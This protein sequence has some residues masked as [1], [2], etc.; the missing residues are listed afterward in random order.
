MGKNNPLENLPCQVNMIIKE[1]LIHHSERRIMKKNR[2]DD[3]LT[4][5][6]AFSKESYHKSELLEE[7]L[8]L[9]AE[10]VRLTFN[11]DHASTADLRIWDVERHLEQLN[12]DCGHPADEELQ[13]FKD[14]SKTLCNLI[15]AEISGSCGERKVFRRLEYL[16]SPNIVLR[17]IELSNG[18]L[19]TELDAIVIT[20]KCLTIIEVKNTGKDIF[21]DENGNYFRT[22]EFLKWDCNIAEK[23][24]IKEKLLRRAVTDTGISDLQIKCLV[25][26]TNNRI[27][28]Q[29]KYHSIRTCFISQLNSIIEGFTLNDRY[30][31]Q[32][33]QNLQQSI[34]KYSSQET[35]PFEFDVQKY[36]TDFATLMAK[37]EKA[38]E[39]KEGES[40]EQ[41]SIETDD[42]F[43]KL[44]KNQPIAS[45]QKVATYVKH[46]GIAAAAMST[47]LTM[48]VMAINAKDFSTKINA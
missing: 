37:L 18:T 20:S 48:V 15:R 29:N 7:M 39:G 46:F 28:V 3:I 22:G 26:F 44:E 30:S 35:Y 2:V 34:E 5:I 25:V 11:D 6:R 38:A 45:K 13:Y 36:K 31:E 4:N 42:S 27:E 33:M 43:S 10:I 21:I 17:N 41:V 16:N 24:D 14:G 47:F 12:E 9:Q 23:M 40:A 32:L 1:S 19:R 8:S